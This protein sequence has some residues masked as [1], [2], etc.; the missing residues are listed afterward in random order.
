MGSLRM[1]V[2]PSTKTRVMR[3]RSPSCT[4]TPDAGSGGAPL[5]SIGPPPLTGRPGDPRTPKGLG[6]SAQATTGASVQADLGPPVRNVCD[7][8][9]DQGPAEHQTR[10]PGPAAAPGG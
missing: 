7:V 9:Q 3:E 1:T 10:S 4:S 8:T 5:H 6:G 2:R